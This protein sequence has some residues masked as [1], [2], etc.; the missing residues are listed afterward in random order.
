MIAEDLSEGWY[1]GRCCTNK[2]P[3]DTYYNNLLKD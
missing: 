1:E 3:G 2:K